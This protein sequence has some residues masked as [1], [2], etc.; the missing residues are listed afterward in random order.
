MDKDEAN[1]LLERDDNALATIV[2][3]DI[4]KGQVVAASAAAL[5]NAALDAKDV[6]L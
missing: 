3:L 4:A 6:T 1:A 2:I 5:G